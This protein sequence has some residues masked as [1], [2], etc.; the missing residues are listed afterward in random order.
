MTSTA[1][2]ARASIRIDD[3]AFEVVRIDQVPRVE[4]LPYTLR[5]LL[6][7]AL[8]NGT[9]A[10]VE[11]IA[12]WAPDAVPAGEI[13]FHPSRTLLHDTTG[14]PALVDLASVRDAVAEAGADPGIVE[15]KLPSVLVVDHSLQVEAFARPDAVDL[16]T[17]LD[18]D[19][20]AERYRLLRWA[21]QAFD[22][23]EIVP[24]G[25]GIMHQVNLELLAEVVAVRDG[26][27]RP[28]T[29]VGS[30]SHTTMVNALGVL[31]WGVGGIEVVAA[32]L[33]EPLPMLVPRVV[34]VRLTG[35]LA[36]GTTSTDLVLRVTEL[37][38]GVGVVGCFVEFNG[39][40]VAGLSVADRATVANMAPEYG[41][42][43][44]FFPVDALT[45]EYLRL[46]GRRREHV[47]L[48]ET[49]CKENLLWHDAAAEPGYSKLVE[50][51]LGTVEPSIAG[52]HRPEDRVPLADAAERFVETFRP[53]SRARNRLR[54]GSV[55]I[56]AITSCTNTSNPA[57]M[58]TAG[59]VAKKAAARGLR[60]KPWVKTSLAPGSRVVS[61][62]LRRAGL[63]THLDT[64]GFNTV[65]Y[66]C[67]TCI[68]ASGPLPDEVAAAVEEGDLVACAVLSGN[69]N[70]EARIHPDV[71]AN[72]LMSPALVVAYAL[73]GAVDVDLTREPLATAPDGTDVYLRELWPTPGEVDEAAAAVDAAA[74][75]RVYRDVFRGDERWRALA[76]PHARCFPWDTG[77]SYLRRPP[78]LDGAAGEPPPVED[79]VGARCL[80]LLGD[81]VTTDHISPAGRIGPATPAGRFLAERGVAQRDFNT[82]ATRRGNDEVMVRATFANVRL[83]NGLAPERTGG[84]TVHLPTGEVTTIF[85]AAER[86]RRQHVPLI[87]VAG[88]GYGT[89]S[90]RDWAAKGPKLLGVRAVLAESYERIHRSNLL[91]TGILPL[92]FEP[93]EGAQRLGLT[94]HET[95]TVSGIENGNADRVQITAGGR[96]F[97]ARVRLDTPRERD[98]F[99]HGGILPY[100]FR[101]LLDR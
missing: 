82:Y 56:A 78:H 97:T 5:V 99:R 36:G 76:A 40:G 38:R 15:P 46:T 94:G 30:D 92:Q 88:T 83:R 29:L 39:P 61:D 59:L 17:S 32:M 41:A 12:G 100:V 79:L 1:A 10:E 44:G 48:V 60:R 47:A 57:G 74:F 96:A 67:T 72:Y 81:S 43:C 42:T 66:G 25:N 27:A 6:E 80:A 98:Y 63:D 22:R 20:N 70:F 50:L 35:S 75:E 4:R 31:G 54:D 73:A 86:Y 18:Y 37:L 95:Y 21:Q 68:G 45:L 71:R 77:S 28:D 69:R 19:R 87:V 62:Y 23:L 16:N 90:S 9:E 84:W 65:G 93:G 64:L 24:P 33:G 49:Y 52:P 58:V 3:E 14:V 91:M 11:S 53:R 89:G 34:G 8:R 7:N 51:D 13:Y 101:R 26:I 85:A 2:A 55:V